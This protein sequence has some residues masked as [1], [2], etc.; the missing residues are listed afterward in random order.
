MQVFK[1]RVN[2]RTPTGKAALR[3][4]EYVRAFGER[5]RYGKQYHIPGIDANPSES[6]WKAVGMTLGSDPS[7]SIIALFLDAVAK[8]C[9]P[10]ETK[11]YSTADGRAISFYV[12]ASLDDLKLNGDNH[13]GLVK[14]TEL[15]A[16]LNAFVSAYNAHATAFHS[17]ANLATAFDKTLYENLEVVH[18]SSNS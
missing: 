14:I 3:A 2:G 7:Q 15:T 1:A 11:M 16:A 13:G 4:F 6:T 12:H 9:A 8:T 17:G 5:F 10:G 18:G